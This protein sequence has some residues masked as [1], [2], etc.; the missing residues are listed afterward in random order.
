MSIIKPSAAIE[1]RWRGALEASVLQAPLEIFLRSRTLDVARSGP[2][3]HSDNVTR[4]TLYFLQAGL[5]S[6]CNSN[7]N[8][9]DAGHYPVIGRAA[10]LIS[11]T[12]AEVI[13][14]PTCWRVA[15]LVS[16]AQFLTPWIGLNDA[17]CVSASVYREFADQP[18]NPLGSYDKRLCG[19]AAKA[20]TQN[21]ESQVQDLATQLA[22]RLALIAPPHPAV[23]R[24]TTTTR[25]AKR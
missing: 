14:Q 20:V 8:A 22:A 12:L 25:F 4:A 3:R 6:Y 17:A 11:T 23:F 18:M 7:E 10:C 21:D 2:G 16:V 5:N 15:A 9:L 1:Q 19:I 13:A 24:I